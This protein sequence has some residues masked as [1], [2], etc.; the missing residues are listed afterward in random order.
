MEC[1]QEGGTSQLLGRCLGRSA[2]AVASAHDRL[3]A[4]RAILETSQSRAVGLGT[5]LK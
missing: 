2:D 4:S 1:H 5:A 3:T